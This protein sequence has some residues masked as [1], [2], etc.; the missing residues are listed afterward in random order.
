MVGHAGRAR[1]MAEVAKCDIVC[2]SRPD[3]MPEST[4]GTNRAI[5]TDNG[6]DGVK[7]RTL[8]DS[9]FEARS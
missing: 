1:T 4:G 2:A 9:A 8:S 3:A 6:R 5:Y 7:E